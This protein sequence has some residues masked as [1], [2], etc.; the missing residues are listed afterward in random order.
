MLKSVKEIKKINFDEIRSEEEF[1]NVMQMTDVE[2]NELRGYSQES[3]DE[4]TPY[5]CIDVRITIDV[6]NNPHL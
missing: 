6:V 5:G 3:T 2:F 4:N 1:K